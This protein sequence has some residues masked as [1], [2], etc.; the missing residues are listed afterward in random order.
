MKAETTLSSIVFVIPAYNPTKDLIGVV[1]GLITAGARK[2]VVIDDGSQDKT[3][4]QLLEKQQVTL[5]SHAVN[6][7]KGAA[8]KTAFN[9]ILLQY[10][11]CTGVVTLDAD[12][13]HAPE[14]AVKI[15]LHNCE[16]NELLL[17]VRVF[18][19]EDKKVPLRSRIGNIL[20]RKI[21][22][23]MTGIKVQDTQTGLRRIPRVLMEDCLR[24]K[25]NKYEFEMEMLLRAKNLRIAITELPI[26][27]IYINNNQGSHF[28]PILDSAR[29]YYVLARYCF[30]SFIS[31]LVDYTC[32]FTLLS[33][34]SLSIGRVFVIARL[35]AGTVNYM[36]NKNVV[37][38]ASEIKKYASVQYAILV[39]FNMYVGF[40]MIGLI[41]SY[42]QNLLL[43]KI[44]LELLLFVFNFYLQKN[45]IFRDKR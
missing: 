15:A 45:W 23:A 1:H 39:S 12:G 26:Q 8:L 24:I 31:F 13:Q 37:F 16:N 25:E 32:F 10:P 14:D 43:S 36:L 35:F 40:H 44:F 11:D 3:I 38:H 2:I 9:Y 33:L 28:N 4:F 30:A 42:S 18:H 27:L 20:T 7:G 29:I 19:A 34:S 21:W 41:D 6:L 22:Q 5:L 17:G